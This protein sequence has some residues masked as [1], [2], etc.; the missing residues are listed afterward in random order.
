MHAYFDS[1]P[2]LKDKKD[3]LIK[4]TLELHNEVATLEEEQ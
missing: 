1:K 2:E 4:K 3:A